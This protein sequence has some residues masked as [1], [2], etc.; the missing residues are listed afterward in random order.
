M[1]R[2]RLPPRR[3]AIT[4]TLVWG[5]GARVHI[6]AGITPDG[7]ILECFLAGGKVGSDRDYLLADYAVTLSRLLQ[8]GDQIVDIAQ[9]IGRL[10]GGE[11]ASVV[12]AVVDRLLDMERSLS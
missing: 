10:P 12:G 5:D 11:P 6:C 9:G 2:E 3:P 7:R 1:T 4:E 8:H